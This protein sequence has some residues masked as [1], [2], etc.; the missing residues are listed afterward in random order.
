MAGLSQ[1]TTQA[2]ANDLASHGLHGDGLHGDA[3]RE[4]VRRDAPGL[5]VLDVRSPGEFQTAHIQGSYNLPL[6][7][8]PGVAAQLGGLRGQT[9]ALVC[10]TGVQAAQAETVLRGAGLDAAHVLEGGIEGWE[11]AG[12]PLERGRGAWSIERQVRAIAGGLVL[13]GVVGS[14][15]VNR[16]LLFLSGFV[17]GGLLFAGL[18]DTCMMGNLLLRLPYNRVNRMNAAEEVNR[19]L[20]ERGRAT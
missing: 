9:V 13:A 16:K 14:L 8:L 7:R 15:T 3:L 5:V 19:L 11:R 1:E 18:S 2:G 10:R 20:A 6:D 4:A 17:G 12:L